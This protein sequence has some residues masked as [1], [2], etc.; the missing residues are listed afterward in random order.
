MIP[1]EVLR[2]VISYRDSP[3]PNVALRDVGFTFFVFLMLSST[4]PSLNVALL[5]VGFTL[6]LF[7]ILSNSPR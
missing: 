3:S 7:F 6:F 2:E 1:G 5:E 4:P